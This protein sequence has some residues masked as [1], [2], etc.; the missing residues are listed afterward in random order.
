M[1]SRWRG[2]EL[3][4]VKPYLL[5]GAELTWLK[6]PGDEGETASSHFLSPTAGVGA[7]LKLNHHASLNAEYRQNM[8]GGDRRISGVT[9]G[10][11]YAL[12]GADE[13]DADEAK[14]EA[15]EEK[16]P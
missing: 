14:D 8:A 1:L 3:K 9:L 7:E 12:F 4:L 15:A 13:E 2:T 10:L 6:E 11:T 16:K 5:A